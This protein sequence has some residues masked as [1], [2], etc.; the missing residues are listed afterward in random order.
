MKRTVALVIALMLMIS[1]FALYSCDSDTD[2]V[3]SE[4]ETTEVQTTDT[5]T[6]TSDTSDDNK[7]S[8]GQTNNSGVVTSYT[9]YKKVYDLLGSMQYYR[10]IVNIS[11]QMLFYNDIATNGSYA[12]TNTPDGVSL[13][14]LVNGI[15]YV[16]SDGE[17]FVRTTNASDIS[18]IQTGIASVAAFKDMALPELGQSDFANVKLENSEN[19]GYKITFTFN[20]TEN[21]TVDTYTLKTATKTLSAIDNITIDIV[22]VGSGVTETIKYEFTDIN[23][24]FTLSAP[25]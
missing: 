21:G 7:T 22:S 19:G 10:M 8:G 18:Q 25:I 15:G 9:V 3:D 16:S 11:D 1:M 14:F 5:E 17:N 20:D 12:E 4:Q 23:G 13:L 6:E 2:T 24:A